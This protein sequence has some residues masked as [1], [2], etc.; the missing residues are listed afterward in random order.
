MSLELEK[1]MRI[2]NDLVSCCYH[3]GAEEFRIYLKHNEDASTK[4][5]VACPIEGVTSEALE[6][7]RRVLHL[8]R[9]REVEQQYWELSGETEFSGELSLVGAMSDQA[10]VT[11]E[12]NV[13]CIT[14][15]R[16]G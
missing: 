6:E 13:L 9:Q 11:Y 12:D 15:K 2:I 16:E 1:S 7:M 4:M 8:P 5:Q 14:V 10:D 3:Q